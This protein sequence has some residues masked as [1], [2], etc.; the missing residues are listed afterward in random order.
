MT[1]T[2]T[3]ARLL[4][5]PNIRRMRIASKGLSVAPCRIKPGEP[6]TEA[7]ISI[8][9][10]G[11]S[12]GKQVYLHT[13]INHAREITWSTK[14]AMD[15]LFQNGL[16]VRNQSVLLKGVNDNPADMMDLL[17]KMSDININPVCDASSVPSIFNPPK[18]KS[19]FTQHRH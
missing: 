1:S 17:N 16:V 2:L 8:A 10:K 4:N 7:L 14:A 9:K 6:W 12:M 19:S 13:H 15:H 11:R 5:M 18:P 3:Y